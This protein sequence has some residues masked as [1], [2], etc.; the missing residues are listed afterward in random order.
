MLT[1]S[2]A[3]YS[4]HFEIQSSTPALPG[5]LLNEHAPAVRRS[6]ARRKAAILRKVCEH[7]EHVVDLSRLDGLGR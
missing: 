3:L 1:Q 5:V 4:V 6:A 7:V 2:D